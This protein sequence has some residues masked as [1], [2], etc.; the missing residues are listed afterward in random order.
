MLPAIFLF[1]VTYVRMLVFGKYRPYIALASGVIFIVTGM[2]PLG[3][4]CT[5]IGASANIAG[6]GILRKAGYEVKNSDFFRIGIPFTFAAIIPA[7][8][9]IWLLFGV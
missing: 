7:Y 3:G 9:Y 4:N 5:P 2:L 6:I 8:I 1:A